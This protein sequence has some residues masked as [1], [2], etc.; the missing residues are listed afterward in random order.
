[1]DAVATKRYTKAR[2]R[3]VLTYILVNAGG[4]SLARCGPCPR[5]LGSRPGLSQDRQGAGGT[6]D[7]DGKEPW[8]A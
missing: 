8:T 5:L 7:A 6:G 3:R 4:N 1:M 2:V